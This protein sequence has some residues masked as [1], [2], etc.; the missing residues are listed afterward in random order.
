MSARHATG[1]AGLATSNYRTGGG[2]TGKTES[3][4]AQSEIF[5]FPDHFRAARLGRLFGRLG[6][7][8]EGDVRKRPG[9]HGSYIARI[10]PPGFVGQVGRFRITSQFP[11][12]RPRI[13]AIVDQDGNPLGSAVGAAIIAGIVI[14]FVGRIVLGFRDVAEA[15]QPI[16]RNVDIIFILLHDGEKD[17][18]KFVVVRK[19]GGVCGLG[20][21]R[22]RLFLRPAN[23][24]GHEQGQHTGRQPAKSNHVFLLE[25]RTGSINRAGEIAN[26][27]GDVCASCVRGEIEDRGWG[28]ED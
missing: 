11:Q 23:A 19:A 12:E 24:R 16:R 5:D 26:R 2:G 22:G 4:A 13:Q 25:F 15:G 3:T 27:K 18:H 20:S 28:I 21:L 17:V 9:M 10:E 8:G 1:I 14:R 7:Q 6:V